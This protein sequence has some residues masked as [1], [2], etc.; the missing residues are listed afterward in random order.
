MKT[1]SFFQLVE[2][3]RKKK[4]FFI[5]P[6]GAT[7]TFVHVK[8]VARALIACQ[9]APNGSVYNLSSDC[10][11]EVLIERIASL[12]GVRSPRLRIP[13][14]PLRL[15]IRALEGHM[16]LPLNSSRLASLT[17]RSRYSSDRIIHE[18]GFAFSKP[19]PEG[20]EDVVRA[21]L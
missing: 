2:A 16:R 15:V 11:W 19:M 8:D 12:V 17:N 13:A 6:P 1:N 10:T 4:F 9:D 7:A 14:L 3:V 21:S 20:I 5:G 18:L